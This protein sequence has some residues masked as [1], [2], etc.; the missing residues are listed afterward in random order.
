MD[1]KTEPRK[2]FGL[3][4]LFI[5]LII[6]ILLAT[7]I[8]TILNKLLRHIDEETFCSNISSKFNSVDINNLNA[9]NFQDMIYR[10]YDPYKHVNIQKD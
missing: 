9:D 7:G 3:R 4:H 2:K 10:Y 5:A 6:L 8:F 1:Y